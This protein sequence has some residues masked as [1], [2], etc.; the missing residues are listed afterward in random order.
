[1]PQYDIDDEDSSALVQ[2]GK[3]K[4][5]SVWDDQTTKFYRKT[6][7]KLDIAERA[8]DIAKGVSQKPPLDTLEN[9]LAFL[10]DNNVHT[11]ITKKTR[12]GTEKAD[13]ILLQRLVKKPLH[14]AVESVPG[15]DGSFI[16]L[17]K[18]FVSGEVY[19]FPSSSLSHMETAVKTLLMSAKVEAVDDAVLL[20]GA[21][22]VFR[23]IEKLSRR[24]PTEIQH[25]M[26]AT[27]PI[28]MYAGTLDFTP[29]VFV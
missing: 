2:L 20:P 5:K 16:K 12:G 4:R 10:A 19:A 15:A 29:T 22:I 9:I 21:I 24:M 11:R 8:L 13:L 3:A 27:K 23:Y 17:F 1:M 25:F 26:D 14:R 28:L 6:I 18:Q 7:S